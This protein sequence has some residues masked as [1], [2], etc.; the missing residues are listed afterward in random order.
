MSALTHGGVG[1]GQGGMADAATAECGLDV[2]QKRTHCHRLIHKGIDAK[3][4]S[5]VCGRCQC[6]GFNADPVAVGAVGEEVG[7][8]ASVLP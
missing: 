5:G 8:P 3:T 7:Q 6:G 2:V 1:I 4:L